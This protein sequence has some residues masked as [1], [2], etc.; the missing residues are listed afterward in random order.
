[1]EIKDYELVENQGVIVNK[2]IR[3]GY[4]IVEKIVPI[5]KGIEEIN[6]MKAL[7]TYKSN[8]FP[9]LIDYKLEDTHM[10]IVMSKI[11]GVTFNQATQMPELLDKIIRNLDVFKFNCTECLK[12]LHNEGVVHRDIKP[13]NLIVDWALNVYIIDFGSACFETSEELNCT[14]VGTYGYM[15]PEMMFSGA[16]IHFATDYYGLGKSLLYLIKSYKHLISAQQYEEILEL[17][18]IEIEKREKNIE[19]L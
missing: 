11:N 9:K 12:A 16:S 6:I 17:C 18:E 8:C 5:K 15:S 19:R 10:K 1:M 13:D 7:N 3:S 14:L 2:H 4:E